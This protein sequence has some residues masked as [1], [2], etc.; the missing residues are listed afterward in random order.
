VRF[1]SK[2]G[3]S[4]TVAAVVFGPLIA[5]VVFLEARSLLLERIVNEQVESALVV[6]DRI[7]HTLFMASEDMQLM[8]ADNFLVEYLDTPMLNDA[9]VDM[10]ADNMAQRA[11][12]TSPW[13]GMSVFDT[14]GQV[15]FEP[16]GAGSIGALADS[17][18][19]R[20]AFDQAMQGKSYNSDRIICR[21]T[22]RPV[23]IFATPIFSEKDT[24]RVVGV[25]VSHLDWTPIQRI[26]DAVDTQSTIHLL[27]S[28]GELIGQ[29]SG[30]HHHLKFHVHSG[31]YP[32]RIA[33]REGM[34]GYAILDQS[35]HDE[36]AALLVDVN[37]GEGRHSY[38]GYGWT[39]MLERP[40]ELMF[41]P[42]VLL[43]R[44]TGLLVIGVLLV[45]AA[46]FY[47]LG[48][49]LVRPLGQLV[50]GVRLVQQGRFDQKVSVHSK[51]EF[52]ELADNFNIMIDQLREAQ[53]ELLR[54]ERLALLGLVA[55]NVGHELRNPL[56]VMSNA[57]Y[58]LR[59]V[60]ADAD[61]TTL[62]YLDI[63]QDEIKR[64]ERIATDLMGAVNTR[65]P[66]LTTLEL[67]GLVD[68]V[69]RNCDVPAGITV[70][71]DIPATLPSIRADDHQIQQAFGNLISNAT[72]AMPKGGVLQ[73]R[74]Y[75]DVPGRTV[76]IGVSDT[77]SGI[78]PEHMTRLF[79]PL[80]TTKARGIGLGLS[81]AKNLVEANGGTITV[82]SEPGKGSTFNVTLPCSNAAAAVA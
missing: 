42:I 35:T 23:V 78:L 24:G 77:G 31:S 47:L 36:K 65:P 16:V 4:A 19:T 75:E 82:Y 55:G 39:L 40:L 57:V 81:V 63:I 61:E 5:V 8:A 66:D 30:E 45:M 58:Y 17:P 56:G 41:T 53:D 38:R 22:G 11:R 79:Q 12:L 50:N 46:V 2:I 62:E 69:L 13:D 6:M 27:N 44:D 3:L 20:I 34:A 1:S 70:N 60:L 71:L 68:E 51:D 26:L 54:K 29:R 7:N 80:F 76:V 49:R 15:V 18:M 72:D 9:Q 32:G 14:E 52:G 48:H 67:A 59:T 43:A 28:K 73:I 74:A 37:Q 10:V 25:L 64:S 33:M 21:R